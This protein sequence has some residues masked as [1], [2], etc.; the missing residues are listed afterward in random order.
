MKAILDDGSKYIEHVRYIN[1]LIPDTKPMSEKLYRLENI[2]NR[3]FAQTRRA[4]EN[5]KDLR[6]FMDYY[7][8]T[9]T[10]LLN[11][12][13]DLMKQDSDVEN[14]AGPLREIEDTMDTVN[15]AFEKLFNSMFQDMAWDISSD[16]SVMKTMMKQ[17]GLTPDSAISGMDDDEPDHF[18]EVS[19]AAQQEE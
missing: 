3:I 19:G 14:V 9:T 7:L 13:V 12:Y 11:A 4:P 18:D 10:K 2:M 6:R 15:D 17:D 1:D 5:A 8:P 16:I